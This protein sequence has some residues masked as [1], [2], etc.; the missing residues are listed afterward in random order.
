MKEIKIFH[1]L[2][3]LLNFQHVF[4]ENNSLKCRGEALVTYVY[5]KQFV[6]KWN[7]DFLLLLK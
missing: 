3:K 6:S 5:V 7:V 4:E 1:Q 2:T